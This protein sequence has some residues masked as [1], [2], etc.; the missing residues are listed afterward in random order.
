[1]KPTKEPQ[2]KYDFDK[3]MKTRL[4]PAKQYPLFRSDHKI[5]TMTITGNPSKENNG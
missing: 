3:F 2:P 4:N 1:M 5:Y